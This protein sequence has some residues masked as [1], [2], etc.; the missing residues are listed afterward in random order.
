M[1][2]ITLHAGATAVTAVTATAR[3]C[4]RR[5]RLLRRFVAVN[6]EA[7]IHRARLQ[8]ELYR[9]RDRLR[10]KTDDDLPIVR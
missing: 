5:K 8:A 2:S 6:A 3:L 4:R 10:T 9:N 7:R 1:T